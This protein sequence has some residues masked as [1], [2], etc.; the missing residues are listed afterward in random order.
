[1]GFYENRSGFKKIPYDPRHRRISLEQNAQNFLECRKVNE[2]E[3]MISTI[4][5]LFRT[6]KNETS[7]NEI[8]WKSGNKFFKTSFDDPGTGEFLQK[9]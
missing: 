6:R 3:Y 9:E 2:N 8:S 4:G 5:S 7:N 1:M